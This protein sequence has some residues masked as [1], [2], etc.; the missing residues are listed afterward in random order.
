VP[1]I[2]ASI[3]VF[4]VLSVVKIRGAES[5]PW[6]GTKLFLP[7][8]HAEHAERF[9]RSFVA[10][11]CGAIHPGYLPAE[12]PRSFGP[13]QDSSVCFAWSAGKACFA[14]H[15]TLEFGVCAAPGAAS[16][17]RHGPAEAFTLN[18]G[19]TTGRALTFDPPSP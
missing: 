11:K 2:L 7:A 6:N 16:H 13:D 4:S 18:C 1:A 9:F 3:S 14:C 19:W 10:K 5:R 8:E 12:D 15:P 17:E